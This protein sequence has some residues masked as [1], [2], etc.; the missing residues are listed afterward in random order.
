MKLTIFCLLAGGS[1]RSR[2]R[3]TPIVKQTHPRGARSRQ[4][5]RR[6]D[7]Q[8]RSLCERPRRGRARRS[9]QGADPNWR[10][11]DRGRAGPA[12]ADNDA[13]VQI[14][15][16][17]GLVNVYLPGYVKTGLSGTLSRVGTSVKA[18][19]QRHQ[20]PG[21]R[22][23]RAGAPRRH[24]RRWASWRAAGRAWTRGPMPRG[25]WACCAGR[26]RSRI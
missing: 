15:A 2:R 4:A 6:G 18:Q 9:R 17:D 22:P 24:R 1:S 10:P 19:I 16:T 5:G 25:L 3:R 26:R 23:L 12:A 7:S 13:E 11:Q 21:D 14:R 20:R 8:D